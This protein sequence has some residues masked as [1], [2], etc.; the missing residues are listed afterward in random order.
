MVEPHMVTQRNRVISLDKEVI[1][2]Q[3]DH[4]VST[5]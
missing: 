2:A 5:N 4:C 3:E 1:I